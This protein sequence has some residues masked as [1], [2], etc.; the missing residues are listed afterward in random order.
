MEQPVTITQNKGASVIVI[1]L[2]A[3]AA[4]HH[5]PVMTAGTTCPFQADSAAQIN[6]TGARK[7]AGVNG[8][9]DSSAT[10]PAMMLD[11]QAKARMTGRPHV[12]SCGLMWP[13]IGGEGHRVASVGMNGHALNG[14]YA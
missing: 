2:I 1:G 8:A 5:E 14:R 6:S 11:I 10:K 7:I 3:R 9:A 12:A 4:A 13:H